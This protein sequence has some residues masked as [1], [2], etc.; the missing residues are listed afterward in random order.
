L[1]VGVVDRVLGAGGSLT[2]ILRRGLRWGRWARGSNLLFFRLVLMISG[3]K[4]GVRVVVQ[5]D[6]DLGPML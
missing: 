4:V 1:T 2:F 6:D 5:V 3:A